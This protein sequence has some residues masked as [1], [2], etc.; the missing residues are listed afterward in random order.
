[1]VGNVFGK[2][3]RILGLDERKRKWVLVEQDFH[4]NF[5]V[6]VTWFFAFFASVLDWIVL[7]LVW[8]ER[9]L[10]PAHVSGQSC[11]WLFKLMLS[12]AVKRTKHLRICCKMR[13]KTHRHNQG[14]NKALT[15]TSNLFFKNRE[16]W[17]RTEKPFSHLSQSLMCNENHV[18]LFFA[19]YN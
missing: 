15:D 8:F 7:I 16:K 3:F 19:S 17:S 12:Q 14:T 10:H 5:Q 9:S 18:T 2:A 11:P 6:N 1:M 4:G 13:W